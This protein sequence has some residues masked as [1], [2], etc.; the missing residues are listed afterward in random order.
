M[1]ELVSRNFI[2]RI[3]PLT[4]FNIAI[5]ILELVSMNAAAIFVES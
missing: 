5:L 3:L 4:E 2:L 1:I